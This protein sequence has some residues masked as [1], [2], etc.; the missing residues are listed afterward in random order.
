MKNALR[1]SLPLLLSLIFS[2]QNTPSA[3]PHPA[4]TQIFEGQKEGEHEGGA[5][6]QYV[7]ISHR[8]PGV[9]WRAIE[10]ENHRRNLAFKNSLRNGVQSRESFAGGQVQGTW[11][12][13]GANNQAGS[14]V[15][16]DFDA[17]SAQIYTVGAGG[18]IFRGNYDG[19]GWTS[20]NDDVLFH[21]Q[22][23]QVVQNSGTRRLVAAQGKNLRYS[24]N[25]GGTWSSATGLSFYD[26]WGGPFELIELPNG[27]LYYLVQTWIQSPWSSG[28]QLY[29]STNK[30]AAWSL[31]QAFTQR[32]SRRVVLWNTHNTNNL[33]LI[34]N[35]TKI[36]TVSGS[37]LTLLHNMSGLPSNKPMSFTGSAASG[38]NKMYLLLESSDL[39]SST[40]NGATWTLTNT[41]SPDAW[42]VG[43]K[44]NPFIANTLYYGEV[45]F[46]KSSNGG[47]SWAKQNGWGEYYSNTNKLHA[48]IMSI[49]PF[50]T[51]GGTNFFLVGNHGGMH[52]STNNFGSTTTN[53]GLLN[54]NV[55]Q[56][57]E[58]VTG[59][60]NGQQ[61]LFIGTQDQ[62]MQRISNASGTGQQGGTQVI[63]GDY[64]EMALSRNGQSLW[65]EYPYGTFM[66][67]HNPYTSTTMNVDYDG[68]QGDDGVNRQL[69]SV[70]MS[71]VGTAAQ[72][73][74]LVGGGTITGDDG[75]YL[76]KLT[77]T[78]S[79]YT[80]TP[81]QFNYN[82]RPQANNGNSYI[83]A[84]AQSSANTARYFVSMA[85]GTFF[86][87]HDNGSTWQKTQNF[88]GPG[89][90]F[91]YGTSIVASPS[92]ANRVYVGG[93]GYGG[94]GVRRSFNGG[95]SFSS[96]SSGLPN[97]FVNDLALNASESLLFAATESGPYVCVLS[98]GQWFSLIGATTPLQPFNSVEYI[99]SVQTVRFGTHG[100]GVWDLVLTAQP[101]PVEW[102]RFE[103]EAQADRSVALHWETGAEYNQHFFDIQ[104][105]TDGIS[106]E[107]IGQKNA[108]G[109]GS[110]YTFTD[111]QPL[112]GINYYRLRQVDFDEKSSFSKTVSAH[113]S[114]PIG[115]RVYPSA[116]V[117]GGHFQVSAE[118]PEAFQFA[119]YS[120][121]GRCVWQT[122]CR[123]DMTLPPLS[124]GVYV[125]RASDAS[126]RQI[127]TG[128]LVVRE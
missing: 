121:D 123:A 115:L 111:A 118:E 15:A 34:D 16:T 38:S 65:Q 105:S 32:D 85:D 5:Y 117:S 14:V 69:W 63:S 47:A 57:Y 58:H 122:P 46:W 127:H 30:G 23:L 66:Y 22:V 36:Y 87:S 28:Y 76:V 67:Y 62:G 1:L 60:H 33:Y 116:I 112:A 89:N 29:R 71:P 17:A 75:S 6:E 7:E 96:L 100:R 98:T 2:C 93:N 20:L 3:P 43:I 72:N 51:S 10:A 9:D 40:D 101:L 124:A 41:L 24:D 4:P 56:H 55:G 97:T 26:S 44:A 86:Y 64:V 128:K 39:Y 84:V 59:F 83:T 8:T 102:V 48:D 107:H 42:S 106:F 113:I 73:A 103:A 74:V 52:R 50:T 81:I 108:T 12:E 120:A 80:I 78:T 11:Y 90:A 94:N 25:E 18:I 27:D 104:R 79:P 70:P 109:S 82:F 125:Y 91:L 19:T 54:L 92:N 35:G 95:V 37:T 110:T 77:A 31:V 45:E 114:S 53:I 99:A 49:S 21:T 68:V 119:L 13:R 126:T 88:S 61:Y